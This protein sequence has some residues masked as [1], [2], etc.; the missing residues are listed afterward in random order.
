MSLAYLS[1]GSNVGDRLEYLRAAL[2]RLSELDNVRLEAVSPVYET[3]PVGFRDQPDFL[4]LAVRI[5]TSLSPEDLLSGLQR[6]EKDLGRIRTR[7]F[8]PRTIDIDILLFENQEREDERLIL[9]HP[10]MNQRAFVLIPLRDIMPDIITV[11]PQ[12]SRVRYFC[13]LD[14]PRPERD[15]GV[16]IKSSTD[17]RKV[18]DDQK[19]DIMGTCDTPEGGFK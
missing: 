14:L 11:I 2:D 18:E 4:N 5:D 19:T 3:E 9:P 15:P 13:T 16:D 17:G 8:G 7:R 10:R 1:M 6:I 12:D